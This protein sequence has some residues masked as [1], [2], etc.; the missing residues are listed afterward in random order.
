MLLISNLNQKIR[1]DILKIISEELNVTRNIIDIIE[2]Y[3]IFKNNLFKIFEKEYEN[4]Y[5]DSRDEDVK[6]KEKFIKKK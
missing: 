1:D 6:E 4:Q 2:A 3:L 5:N